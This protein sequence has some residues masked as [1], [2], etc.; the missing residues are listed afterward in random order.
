MAKVAQ[1]VKVALVKVVP[2]RDQDQEDI[3]LQTQYVSRIAN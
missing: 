1:M 2:A 3:I